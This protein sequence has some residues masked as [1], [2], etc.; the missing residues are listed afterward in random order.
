M[1]Y[2]YRK[3]LCATAAI[4]AALAFGSTPLLAQD[5][6][7]PEQGLDLPAPPA[8]ALSV[9][10]AP[11]PVTP[12][13]ATPPI[14]IPQSIIDQAVS[15]SAGAAAEAGEAAALPAASAERRAARSS[16]AASAGADAPASAVPATGGPP[17]SAPPVM[18]E[19]LPQAG[20]AGAPVGTPVAAAEAATAP[21]SGGGNNGTLPDEA[22]L[23]A[24]LGVAGLGAA[25]FLALRFR[26]RADEVV[27]DGYAPAM[28]MSGDGAVPLPA[29]PPA[30]P[31]VT[32]SVDADPLPPVVPQRSVAG[33]PFAMPAGPVPT[34]VA[35]QRLLGQMV[36]AAPDEANPFTSGNARR[37]RA[38]IILQAREKRLRDEATQ[39]FDWRTYRSPAEDPAHPRFVDA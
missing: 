36:A 15:D 27:E 19:A 30:E 34:G 6:L 22:I 21:V 12:Q 37:K 24:L 13:P 25:G 38:R 31:V 14:V 4:S 20:R 33:D 35:R 39:P 32:R 7:T 29:E 9:P 2:A 5:A 1:T 16:A 26:R 11:A 3:S 10:Q 18:A 17:A 23:A 28:P 8:P